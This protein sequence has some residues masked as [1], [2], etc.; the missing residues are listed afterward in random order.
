MSAFFNDE[1]LFKQIDSSERK[2]NR[3][4]QRMTVQVNVTLALHFS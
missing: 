2:A 4:E 3:K 1:F